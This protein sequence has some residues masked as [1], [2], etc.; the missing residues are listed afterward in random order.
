[1]ETLLFT[2]LSQTFTFPFSMLILCKNL[3]VITSRWML[4]FFFFLKCY[5]LYSLYNDVMCLVLLVLFKGL[6]LRIA[7]LWNDVNIREVL[8][9]VSHIFF[10]AGI[11]LL[12]LSKPALSSTQVVQTQALD[13]YIMPVSHCTEFC[14]LSR[15][16]ASSFYF[17]LL[18]YSF[19]ICNTC[20]K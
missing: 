20:L 1:M 5:W 13:I 17:F 7:F 16:T 4:F 2:V 12:T 14:V 15:S 3:S 11:I 18:Y 19:F 10:L 6:R 8:A 9:V